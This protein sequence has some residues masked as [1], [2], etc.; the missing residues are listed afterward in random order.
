MQASKARSFDATQGALLKKIILF[1]IPIMLTGILQQ[2]YNAADMMVVGRFSQNGEVSLAAVGTTGALTNLMIGLFMGLSVGAGVSVAHHV[3]ERRYDQVSRVIHTSITLSVVLGVAVAIIGYFAAPTMLRWMGAPEGAVRDNAVL[4]IRI[5]FMGF[6]ASL[7]YNYCASMLRS[8]GDAKHPLMF[9]SIS[10]VVN[11]LLNVVLV[12]V[13]HLDVAGV[14]I[15]TVSANY[16]S[17]VMILVYMGRSK[18]FMHFSPRR[19]CIDRE[20]LRKILY[21]GIPSGIQG[22]LFSF[23]NVL[24]QSAVN[25]FGDTMMAGA[26]A[27]S[28]I[29]SFIYV[30]LNA[31]Y[32]VALTFVGQNIGAKTYHNIKRIVWYCIGVVTTVG[33]VLGVSIILFNKPLIGLFAPGNEAVRQAALI[34][35]RY[36]GFPYFLCGIMEVLCGT[37]RAMGKSMTSMVIS[38]CGACGVRVL[39]LQT[40]FK[41]LP[42]PG[43]VFL[44]YPISWSITVLAYVILLSIELPRLIKSQKRELLEG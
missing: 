26:A 17:C 31:L 11:V 25:S 43:C 19:L 39:W 6:P 2:F 23:S 37:M 7:L 38:L 36:I 18:D 41:L 33:L 22:C 21:I 29:E 10:G 28:N 13:F 4:Y 9:L 3:G 20:K 44:S 8:A 30:T 35:M 24:I 32:H 12:A 27:A 14:A 42:T 1:A 40:M 34:K 15:A 5:I 16:L